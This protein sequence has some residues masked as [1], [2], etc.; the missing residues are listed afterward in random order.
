MDLQ[1]KD[2]VVVV[3]GGAKGIGAAIVRACAAEGAIPVIVDRDIDAGNQLHLALR[4]EGAAN[5]FI[6]AELA[7]VEACAAAILQVAKDFGRIDALVNNAGVNDKVG[8]EHGTPRRFVESLEV[9]LMPYYNMAHYALPHLKSSHGCIVNIASK[10]AVTGQGGT[11]G[12]VAAKGGILGLTR[13]WAAELLPAGIRVNA[14]IPAEVMTPMYREWVDTFT[15]PE[16]KLAMI[17]A[18]IPLGKRMTTPEE[19][20]STVVFLLSAKSGHTTGQHLFVDG[21]YTHL[22]RALT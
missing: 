4:V 17:Q 12:Y 20:A 7:Q 9:N 15:N 13:E 14:I 1:L 18:N 10:T 22:D 19:I 21:G 3:T 6:A 2:K 8:L 16:E 11:S 5:E